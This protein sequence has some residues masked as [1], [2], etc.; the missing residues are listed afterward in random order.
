MKYITLK[1]LEIDETVRIDPD[2]I[3]MIEPLQVPG[4]FVTFKNG[5]FM[6]YCE[7]PIE[8]KRKEWQTRYLWP[9]CERV[10][11]AAI[12][13]LLAMLLRSL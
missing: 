6:R 11:I 12:G 7:T 13:A 9:N 4:S 5:D 10:L 3:L 1:K 2:E 8:I